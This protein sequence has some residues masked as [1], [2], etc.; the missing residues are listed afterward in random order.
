M[1]DI[2]D[3]LSALSGAAPSGP[4][5][6]ATVTADL[7]RGR[8]ARRRRRVGRTAPAA[9]A[10][11]AVAGALTWG[12]AGTGTSR[13]PAKQHSV[14]AGQIQL[15]A[16]TGPQPD[17]F[18]LARVPAGFHIALSDA[19]RVVLAKAGDNTSGENY[20]GKLVISVLSQDAKA[21]GT[22]T[23]VGGQQ[24]FLRSSDGARFLT[25]RQE[26]YWLEIQSW[27]GIGLTDGQLV[28]LA[29]GVTVVGHPVVPRG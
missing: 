2:E 27:S 23:T 9:V 22:P 10:A 19:G 15:V 14:V 13:P 29:E 11:L 8:S 28:S 5:T 17:G 25:W 26:S 12:L 1:N 21:F 3:R 18:T 4:P 6:D 16:Y 24:A 7:A 20:A